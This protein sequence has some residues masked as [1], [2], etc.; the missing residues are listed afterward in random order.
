MLASNSQTK[1]D[2]LDVRWVDDTDHTSLTMLSLRAVE[3]DGCGCVLD[4]VGEGPVGN[5]LSGNGRDVAGEETVVR[6][7]AWLG[8]GAL[9]DGVVL[10]PETESDGVTLS[11]G[12]GLRD[13]DEAAGLVGDSDEV[14]FRDSGA[15]QG[16]GSEDR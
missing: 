5:G 1:D 12:N 2:E 8:E 10:G 13:E 9:S 7:R 15:N 11:S 4:F 16:G 6:W 3:P 14:V